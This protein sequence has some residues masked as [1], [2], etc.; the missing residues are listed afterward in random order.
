[1]SFILE[2]V[3]SYKSINVEPDRPWKM[4][5]ADEMVVGANNGVTCMDFDVLANK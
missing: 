4:N 3:S 2:N 5:R 1:M